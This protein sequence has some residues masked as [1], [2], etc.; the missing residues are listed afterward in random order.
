MTDFSLTDPQ[1]SSD[2]PR[3]SARQPQSSRVAKFV[4]PANPEADGQTQPL[5]T[6]QVRYRA[7]GEA[8]AREGLAA[9]LALLA[10]CFDL[11]EPWAQWAK[12]RMSLSGRLLEAQ[13]LR[14]WRYVAHPHGEPAHVV[15]LLEWMER[16]S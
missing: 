6:R 1:D 9:R 4:S 2:D 10:Q 15:G 7:G 8:S 5:M 13:P 16:L 14:V 12:T 3:H 11:D